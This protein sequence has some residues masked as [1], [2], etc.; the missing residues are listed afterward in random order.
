MKID[1]RADKISDKLEM[2]SMNALL[3]QEYINM[4]NENSFILSRHKG[5]HGRW[6]ILLLVLSLL[7]MP[8]ISHALNS[9][10]KGLAIAMEAAEAS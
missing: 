5:K 1:N 6:P 2:E 4:N 7:L 3:N 10:E 9:E 8:M